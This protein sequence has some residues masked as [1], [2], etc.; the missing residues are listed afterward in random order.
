MGAACGKE[1]VAPENQVSVIEISPKGALMYAVGQTQQFTTTLTTEAGTDG[2]G[3][4]VTYTARDNTL[5][6]VSPTGVA[7]T[8][9]TGGTTYVVA[10]A[11]GKSDSALVQVQA[12]TCPTAAPTTMTVGQ[13]VTDIGDA[14]FCAAASTGDYAVI[15]HNTS[16]AAGGF[17]SLE[18]T[19]IGV[20]TPPG[21]SASFSRSVQADLGRSTRPRRDAAAE[22]RF[23]R[24]EAIVAAPFAATARSWYANRKRASRSVAPPA[25]GDMMHINVNLSGSACGDSTPVDAR[26]TAVSNN[27]IVLED[28]RN[29]PEGFTDSAYNA[30]AQ[31]FDAT[32]FPLDTTQ[33]GSPT[34]LDG[35][36]RVLLV[37]T[38][39]VN[40]RTPPNVN[41]YV[42]G[43]TYSRDLLPKT[44][45][46]I[47]GVDFCQT[48]NQAEMF[49][50]M[51]PDPTSSV[52][53]NDNFT[54]A[55]VTS[56]TEVTIAHE[57]QHM[58]NFAR[59]RYLNPDSPQTPAELWL[60]EG[61]SHMAEELLFYART[62]RSP[63]SNYGGAQ[64][65]D[66]GESYNQFLYYASGDWLNYDEYV[67]ATTQTSPFEAGDDLGTRGATWSFL[68]YLADQL[69]PTDGPVWHNLVN[70]GES[71]L[72]NLENRFSLTDETLRAALRDFAI[73]TYTDDFVSGVAKRFTQPSWNMRSIYP[74]VNE[75]ISPPMPFVWPLVG[76]G[77]HDTQSRTTTLQ[78]GGF[79]VYRFTGLAGTDSF[80]RVKGSGG[81]TL[82]PN[83]TISVVRT[84]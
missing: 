4:A 42:G 16:F 64:I 82:P 7:T 77:L 50:L 66:A 34:D 74:R 17:T 61:L 62:G 1:P 23:R 32:I 8:L 84:Q 52:N 18:V 67:F 19:P 69:L 46:G 37:F 56:I 43:L 21:A 35:N 79:K 20:A 54:V 24:Q 5:L 48:G 59:R 83:I 15:V 2:S 65:V 40:E 72:T 27:A 12:S 55:F 49:Y 60:N 70:S 63:R 80:I 57:F 33:F 53:G 78:A 41:Y 73:S 75:I 3:I 36:G 22:M 14:G 25:V 58:I 47:N 38:R 10:T 81:A 11:G 76:T 68:R 45:P 9:K 39:A 6:Q 30:F 26:V 51:V 29:P 31:A 71:G 28:P 13:V 44:G